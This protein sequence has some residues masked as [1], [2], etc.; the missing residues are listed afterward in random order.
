MPWIDDAA[1]AQA[2][3]HVHVHVHL[4]SMGSDPFSVA[5]VLLAVEDLALALATA[6]SVPAIVAEVAQA[7]GRMPGEPVA[8]IGVSVTQFV[9]REQPPVRCG[10]A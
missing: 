6:T 10:L 5:D 4:G 8:S 7:A 2:V 1:M 9:E 3:R